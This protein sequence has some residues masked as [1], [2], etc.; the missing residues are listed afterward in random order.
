MAATTT[1]MMATMMAT[2]A[3]STGANAYAQ[4]SAINSQ[5]KYQEMQLKTN[6]RMA[7][8]QADQAIK[9]GDKEAQAVRQKTKQLIGSQRAALAA[10][11]IEVNADTSADIQADTASLGALDALTV[12]NNAWLESWGYKVQ[13]NDYAGQAV[14]TRMAGKYNAKQTLL[15]GGLQIASDVASGLYSMN[16]TT[17]VSTTKKLPSGWGVKGVGTSPSNVRPYTPPRF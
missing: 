6:E 10:Q 9:R 4:S 11:G 7:N 17:G 12:K 1:A 16:K 3:M 13:A 5:S 15:T 2:Q 14:M 8:I